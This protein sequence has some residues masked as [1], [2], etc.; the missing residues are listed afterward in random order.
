MQM[1]HGCNTTLTFGGMA[2]VG[3]YGTWKNVTIFRL[4]SASRVALKRSAKGSD[5]THWHRDR[6]QHRIHPVCRTLGHPART[7][8]W[9]NPASLEAERHQV[10]E[11]TM[12]AAQ[13]QKSVCQDPTA[14]EC[15]NFAHHKLRDNAAHAT[16]L[17]QKALPVV[18]QGVV[19]Q[20]VFGSV[21]M[22][23]SA[24]G[25]DACG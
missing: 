3:L 13:P 14:Q 22:P 18:L 12:G 11:S 10:I 23:R 8:R 25:A 2:H 20:R 24:W 21:A 5:N 16:R 7:T 1:P 15:I 9:I 4:I 6:R 19:Q 17:R